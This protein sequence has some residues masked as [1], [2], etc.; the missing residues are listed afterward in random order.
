MIHIQM[1]DDFKTVTRYGGI[2]N[3]KNRFTICVTSHSGDFEYSYGSVE[4][5]D[6]TLSDRLKNKA[7]EKIKDFITKWLFDK[8]LENKV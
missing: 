4:W 2:V 3:D 1:D 8:S 7:E 5:K 6:E